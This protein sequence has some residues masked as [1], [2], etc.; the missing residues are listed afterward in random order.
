MLAVASE[1]VLAR[2]DPRH[3]G[4]ILDLVDRETGRQLLGRPPFASAA[5]LGGDL[6]ETTWTARYRGGWQCVTPNAGNPCDVDG[7]HHG[8]HGRASNDPWT[9][10]DVSGR[11]ATLRWEGHGLEVTR[12]VTAG[13][14]GLEVRTAWHATRDATPLVALEHVALG[15]ELLDPEVEIRLPAGRAYE[16]SEQEGPVG[17]PAGAPAWPDALLLDGGTERADRWRLDA[18]R[19]RLLAVADLPAGRAEVVNR[20]TGQGLRLEWD[21][22]A[23]P[24]LW[25]WHEVRTTGGA[26]RGLTEVLCVEPSTVPHSLG[27]AR[28]LEEGQAVVL[29]AADEFETT[30]A[31]RPFTEAT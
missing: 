16:L 14:D 2:I 12:V 15:L 23:Q 4:E 6:D 22:E 13:A 27:L 3:G 5:P 17:P 28:A 18:S 30:I 7:D 21:A 8:F 9:V 29:G 24:H 25:M 1:R 19:S 10:V 31:A 11:H 26:W 20:G